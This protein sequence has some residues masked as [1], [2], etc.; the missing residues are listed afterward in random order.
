MLDYSQCGPKGEPRVVLVEPKEVSSEVTV[1]APNFA[2]FIS[3]LV[4]CSQFKT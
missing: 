4:D 2:A 3:G 1:L